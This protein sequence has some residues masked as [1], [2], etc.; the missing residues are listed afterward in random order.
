MDRAV[1][2]VKLPSREPAFP[3]GLASLV[4]PLRNAGWGAAGCDLDAGDFRAGL[5]GLRAGR[6]RAVGISV[7]SGQVA[8]AASVVKRVRAVAPGVPV[9]IGG[10]HPTLFPQDAL[11]AT[12]ADVAVR[13]DGE[14]VVAA[15]VEAA[16]GDGPLP[17]GCA[18]W[19]DGRFET[20]GAPSFAKDLDALPDPDRTFLPAVRYGRAY[21]GVR[22]PHAPV[23]SSRGCGS[24]CPWC[25][26]P[27]IA[28]LGFRA[29][30]AERVADEVER[31]VRDLGIRA[32]HFEDDAFLADPDRAN[33]L[34]EALR[35]RRPGCVFELVNGVRPEHVVPPVLPALAA[36][37][38]RRIAV[39]FERLADGEETGAVS[40][41][42]ARECIDA[43]HAHGIA[44]TGF[45]VIGLPGTSRGQDERSVDLAIRLGLDLAHFTPYEPIPGSECCPGP[46]VPNGP[47]EDARTLSQRAYRA[48][49][50]SPVTAA[51]VAFDALRSAEL[52][53]GLTR[54]AVRL[55][56][57]S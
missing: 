19:R 17:A 31:L 29:R 15:A 35:R 10:P 3:I 48:F 22:Y 51:R 28:P 21:L 46:D 56:L 14:P 47:E 34:C 43:L 1:L 39:G 18:T 38:F 6:F 41:A 7:M 42:R 49:Y 52:L 37:G 13:G 5:D 55:L 24:F 4:G 30:S 11:R 23:V 50:R 2:L 44:A 57:S 16:T 8:I 40:F 9:L 20:F 25:S 12:G 36:A 54:K 27:A 26:G 33:V 45:L 32:V 53:A